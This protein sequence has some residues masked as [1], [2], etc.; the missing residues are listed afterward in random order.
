MFVAVERL[1]LHDLA[2][3]R[4]QRREFV[5]DRLQC[6]HFV[7]DPEQLRDEVLDVWRDGEQEFRFGEAP[8][9]GRIGS[10]G[11]QPIRERRIDCGEMR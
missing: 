4:E 10:R 7:L 11:G 9:R 6:R 2:L 8:E 3:A 1:A 5:L